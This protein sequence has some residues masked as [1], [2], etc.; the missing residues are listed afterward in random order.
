MQPTFGWM[1]CQPIWST[2]FGATPKSKALI[3]RQVAAAINQEEPLT[4]TTLPSP[5]ELPIYY[6]HTFYLGHIIYAFLPFPFFFKK[7]KE[8]TVILCRVSLGGAVKRPLSSFDS[9]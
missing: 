4:F 2:T 8:E 9:F 1:L 7:K 5:V 3:N 6:T